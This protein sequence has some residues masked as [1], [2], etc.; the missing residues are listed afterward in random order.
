MKPHRIVALIARHLYLYRRSLPRIMEIFYWPFLDLVIW[1]FITLY[2]ARY[3]SQV[4]GFVTFFLGA[5]ILWDMLF[6]SQQGITI[7]FLE[8]LWARNLMNLF[9]SPLKPS[10]FLAATMAMSIMKVTVVSIVMAGCALL[11]YSYNIFVVGLWLAPFV[12]NLVITGWIIGVFTTSLIMR[13]GQEAE[14]LAWSMV[15]LFQPISCVFYPLEVLPA[16]LRPV[17]L[18]NPAAHIFEGMRAVLTSGA[19]PLSHLAWAG[20]LNILLLVGAI[21]WFYRTFAYCKEQGL[22]VRVGE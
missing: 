22:L 1:G 15:F 21:A 10:E 5:L 9:A 13:F 17:A 2:L 11:F 4:P 7:S 16:W 8:E 19:P 20:G 6:R 12:I 18:A 3:Q 14:V